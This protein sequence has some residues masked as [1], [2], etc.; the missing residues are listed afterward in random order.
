MRSNGSHLYG[1][2][3]GLVDSSRGRRRSSEART[4]AQRTAAQWPT[5]CEVEWSA[6]LR[7]TSAGVALRHRTAPR[8]C[9]SSAFSL[10]TSTGKHTQHFRHNLQ[11]HRT[12]TLDAAPMTDY[13]IYF[14]VHCNFICGLSDVIIK[15]FSQSVIIDIL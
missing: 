3:V 1:P 15:T 14:Y 6:V 2:R 9:S 11:H 13:I 7:P 12:I 10:Y 5:R 4:A 8:F